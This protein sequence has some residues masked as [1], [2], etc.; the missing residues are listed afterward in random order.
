ML[1]KIIVDIANTGYKI[2]NKN[3]IR[4]LESIC[5]GVE[6]QKRLLILIKKAQI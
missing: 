4:V 2:D 3:L 6:I 5:R 1:L